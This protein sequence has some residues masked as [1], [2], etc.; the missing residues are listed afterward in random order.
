MGGR[1]RKH[2][3]TRID[4]EAAGGEA[5]FAQE[6][7]RDELAVEL[8]TA[9]ATHELTL[10]G[11]GLATL[12]PLPAD[13]RALRV[14]GNA[15]TSGALMAAVAPAGQGSV[16]EEV[17]TAAVGGTLRLLAAARNSLGE[18]AMASGLIPCLLTCLPLLQDLDLG[19]NQ[20]ASLGSPELWSGS[21]YGHEVP[22]LTRVDLSGNLLSRLP[23]ELLAAC[24]LLHDLCLRQNR[25][26]SLEAARE[27]AGS[28]LRTL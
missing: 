1:A 12:P 16:A 17:Q 14:A 4:H 5:G 6:S 18:G 21:V 28:G 22:A 27:V 8:R 7:A 9:G 13:L 15:L 26:T 11:R 25:I 23:G 2:L 10:E 20:L 24:P 3:R 19:F